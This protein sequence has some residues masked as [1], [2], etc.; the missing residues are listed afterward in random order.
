MADPAVNVLSE[1]SVRTAHLPWKTVGTIDTVGATLAV[2]ARKWSD[3][4]AYFPPNTAL[5]TYLGYNVSPYLNTIEVRF[6]CTAAA[7][8][9]VIQ[10][11]GAKGEDHFTLLATLTLAGGTQSGDTDQTLVFVDTITAS[12]ENLP[13]AGVVIDGAGGQDNIGRYAVHL[14]GYSKLVFN[15][16][17][18]NSNVRVQVSGW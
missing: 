13:V 18:F 5:T 3:F 4:S 7:D 10:M 9:N 17:T 2:T 14:A 12:T 15:A 6:Q 8:A 11:W 16:T 1:G